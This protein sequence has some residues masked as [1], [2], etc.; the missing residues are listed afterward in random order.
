MTTNRISCWAKTLCFCFYLD[1][2]PTIDIQ[3]PGYEETG[4]WL[5]G[6]QHPN[7]CAG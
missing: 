4:L 1:V 2:D 5:F 7:R 3:A 6:L